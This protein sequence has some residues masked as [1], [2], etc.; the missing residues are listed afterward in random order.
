MLK[1]GWQERVSL[2]LLGLTGLNAKIDT[3]AR[4]SALHAT[5]IT[6]F[7]RDGVPWVR[8]HSRFDDDTRDIDVET[9]I[10]DRREITNT[11]G[12]PELRYVI[13]T[14]FAIARRAW[15]IDVSL[16]ERTEMAFRMIVGRSALRGRSVLVDPGARHLT[17]A[18]AQGGRKERTAR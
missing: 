1:I 16:A 13:R 7:E 18:P 11:S 15:K 10:H 4:T 8:F 2:P 17:A 3:G 6:P 12:V 9:P 14:K 5:D